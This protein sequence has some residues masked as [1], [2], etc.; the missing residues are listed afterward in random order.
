VF[1]IGGN[2]GYGWG[3]G[4]TDFA[5]LPDSTALGL[6]NTALDNKPSGAIGGAQIGYNWQMGSF[7]TGL[8]ADIQGSGINGS[9]RPRILPI[10][11]IFGVIPT[12][13]ADQKLSWFGTVRGRVGV[14]ATP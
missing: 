8:E 3:S 13:K 2:V 10:D 9:A 1:N 11:P 4:N 14:A 7:I 12:A 5:F 6:A